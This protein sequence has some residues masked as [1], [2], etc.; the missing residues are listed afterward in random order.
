MAKRGYQWRTIRRSLSDTALRCGVPIPKLPPSQLP[1]CA[2]FII[3]QDDE[4]ML[5]GMSE[6]EL[7]IRR[8]VHR[9]A[10]FYRHVVVYVLVISG[11]WIVNFYMLSGSVA[12]TRWYSY[13]AIWPTAGWGI[14][15][16]THGL[17]VAPFWSFFSQ[18]WEDKKVKQ[19][20]ERDKT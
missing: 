6:R 12:Q 17:S 4:L 1:G 2:P 15:L 18:D 11:L 10:E 19:L 7:A 20:M 3:M 13:W 8:R 14:G 5:P 16:L 9:L